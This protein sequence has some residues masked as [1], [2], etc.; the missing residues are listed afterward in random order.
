MNQTAWESYPV[1]DWG[2]DHARA[3]VALSGS[4]TKPVATVA[5]FNLDDR[6]AKLHVT[7]KQLGVR[8]SALHDLW[9]GKRH[10]TASGITVSLPAHGSAIYRVE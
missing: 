6:P 9:S 3:W 4:H 2:G 10:P 7:W 5:L 8:G 1:A